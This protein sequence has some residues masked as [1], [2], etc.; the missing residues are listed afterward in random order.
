MFTTLDLPPV[1]PPV[2]GTLRSA[3]S[4]LLARI[5]SSRTREATH[6]KHMDLYHADDTILREMGL[7]RMDV[8]RLLETKPS[9]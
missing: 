6:A 1:A 5:G 4:M 7:T 3:L 8:I 2:R 9:R